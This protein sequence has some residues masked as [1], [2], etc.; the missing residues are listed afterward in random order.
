MTLVVAVADNNDRNSNA[1]N[2]VAVVIIMNRA[3]WIMMGKVCFEFD[4][5]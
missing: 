3:G 5:E 1:V 4:F 2:V